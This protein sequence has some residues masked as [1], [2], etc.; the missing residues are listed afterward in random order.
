MS[1]PAFAEL[2][3][4]ASRWLGVGSSVLSDSRSA[5]LEA[6][7]AALTQPD[8]Q[9]L[10]AFYSDNH[11]AA[12][13]A[14]G[15]SEVAGGIPVVGCSSVGEI[16]PDGPASDSVVITA[17]G[18]PGISVRTSLAR[19]A[20]SH[21]R[22]AGA[23]VAECVA[24]VQHRAHTVLMLLTDGLITT[25]DEMLRGVYGVVGA[26]VPLVGGCAADRQRIR[27]TQLYGTEATHDAVIGIAIGSDGPIGIGIDHGWRKVGEAMAVTSADRGWIHTLDDEPALDAYLRRH[28]APALAY[29]DF[30][31]FEAF[32]DRRPLGIPRRHGY[33]VR[34]VAERPNFLTRSLGCSA[35]IAQGSLLWC[36]EGDSATMLA[37]TDGA[38]AAAVSAIGP[39]PAIGLVVFDCSGRRSVLG[40]TGSAEE[41]R[42][43]SAHAGSAPFAG[44]YTFGEIARTHGING[45]H[46]QTLVVMALG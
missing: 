20:G 41:V 33:E 24:A 23:K 21:P 35:E 19:R 10:L 32:V 7:T 46:H 4:P 6:A 18:G 25:Q 17:L 45:F 22:E 13:L 28:D 9:L 27:T 30:E 44:F 29:H 14:A 2:S 43:V 37:A 31:A 26:G 8:A 39:Q 40:A 15:I 1:S 12:A 36:M 3:L 11:D 34:G 38:C 42:R 16:S 5:G